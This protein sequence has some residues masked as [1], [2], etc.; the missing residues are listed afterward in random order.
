MDKLTA[1]K[2]FL[3]V[4]DTGSFSKTAK[5]LDLPVSTVSRRIKDLEHNL[6]VE[7]FRRSTRFLALTDLGK[8]YY[9]RIEGAVKDFDTVEELFREA[10]REPSGVIKISALPSYAD[11]RLYPLVQEFR[12]HYPKITIDLNTTDQVEHLLRDKF[13]FAIRPT[14][15]PPENLVAKVIDRHKMMLVASPEY[16]KKFGKIRDP[17]EVKNHQAL[18]YRSATGVMPWQ[19]YRDGVWQV[20]QKTPYFV[21]NDTTEL[22]R[23]V[24]AGEGISLLP[25]WTTKEHLQ[26]GLVEQI[27]IGWEISFIDDL[28]HRLYLLYEKKNIELKR[29][30]VFLNFLLKN[31]N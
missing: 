9:E 27:N 18:C 5:L 2:Y 23:I 12:L 31:L 14:S 1:A 21:C 25:E 19:S 28:E 22:L 7:L 30:R 11:M 20:V 3:N 13:D 15:K 6:G 24:C 17:D 26:K 8:I 10:T 29:N 16:V 4:A